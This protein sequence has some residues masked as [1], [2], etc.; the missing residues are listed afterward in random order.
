MYYNTVPERW[1]ISISYT[2]LGDGHGVL[3]KALQPVEG[4]DLM[5]K[6]RGV[7]FSDQD[8][9][10]EDHEIA[11]GPLRV[12]EAL[13]ITREKEDQLDLTKSNRLW[14]EEADNMC[15]DMIVNTYILKTM[16]RKTQATGTI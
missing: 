12:T 5:R 3:V 9:D 8:Q 13:G 14:L 15:D 10:L 16:T 11:N 2:V 4:V 6:I 1:L 7:K